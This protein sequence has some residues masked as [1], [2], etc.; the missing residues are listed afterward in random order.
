MQLEE[1]NSDLEKRCLLPLGHKAEVEVLQRDRELVG[2][3]LGAV[4]D[5]SRGQTREELE[6]QVRQKEALEFRVNELVIQVQECTSLKQHLR[7]TTRDLQSE[8]QAHEMTKR[9]V[10]SKEVEREAAINEM[11]KYKQQVSTSV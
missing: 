9:M 1:A 10:A 6:E 3:L 4:D 7:T 2:E 8:Q 5:G 11:Q